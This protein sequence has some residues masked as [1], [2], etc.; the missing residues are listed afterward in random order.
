MLKSRFWLGLELGMERP[1][2]WWSTLSNAFPEPGVSRRSKTNA[3][4]EELTYFVDVLQTWS[5][6]RADKCNERNNG[7]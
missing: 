7:D 5:W 1:A 2:S 4:Y 6:K 3:G